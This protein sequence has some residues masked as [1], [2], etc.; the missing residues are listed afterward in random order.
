MYFFP[1]ECPRVLW[2]PLATTS[3][4][5]LDRYWGD[6]AATRMIACIESAWLPR[7]R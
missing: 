1:R 6:R 4:A 2:W 5:A 7:L 3:P